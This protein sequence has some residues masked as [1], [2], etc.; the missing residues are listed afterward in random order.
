[1][2]KLTRYGHP[3]QEGESSARRHAVAHLRNASQLCNGAPVT[4]T[5]T[6]VSTA[7][8][9]RIKGVT[10]ATINRYVREGLLRAHIQI[11]GSSRGARLY[12]LDDVLELQTSTRGRSR[13]A[14]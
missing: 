14:S 9:A 7:Q 11:N 3:T 6:L 12:L 4:T 8:A 1:M 10:V 5:D 2:R 13:K